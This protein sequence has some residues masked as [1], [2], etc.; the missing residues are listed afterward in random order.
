MAPTRAR[1]ICMQAVPRHLAAQ[2][3][4]RASSLA[5]RA[6]TSSRAEDKKWTRSRKP[7]DLDDN[8]LAYAPQPESDFTEPDENKISKTVK[9]LCGEHSKLG[10]KARH[11]DE[12][13]SRIS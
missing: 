12:I 4:R 6:G 13:A 5:R 9:S 3:E 1:I 8:F 2:A 7:N 11:V 10:I